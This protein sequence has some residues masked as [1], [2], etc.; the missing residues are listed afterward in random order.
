MP[1]VDGPQAN[2]GLSTQDN[3]SMEESAVLVRCVR[4]CACVCVR[5][6]A[7]VELKSW[8]H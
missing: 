3:C 8:K 2:S 6:H 4:V 7:C 5:A 1:E